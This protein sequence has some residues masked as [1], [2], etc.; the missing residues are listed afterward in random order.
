MSNDAISNAVI[1]QEQRGPKRNKGQSV[2]R[3][4]AVVRHPDAAI[5][6][7]DARKRLKSV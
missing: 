5:N 7:S 1:F 4:R 3:F 2:E 6:A